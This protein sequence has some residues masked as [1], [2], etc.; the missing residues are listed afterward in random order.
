VV[1]NPGSVGEFVRQY[2][3]R[4]NAELEIEKM[5]ASIPLV[6]TGEDH[7]GWMKPEVWSHMEQTLREQGV[8]AVPLDLEAT[9]TLRFLREI[10]DP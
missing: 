2:N 10:Y 6:N 4:T 7:I 5:T 3:P 8:L 1:E 9:Y